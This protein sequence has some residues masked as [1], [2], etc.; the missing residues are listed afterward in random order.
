[1]VLTASAINAVANKRLDVSKTS[2]ERCHELIHRLRE[3][4]EAGMAGRPGFFVL[5]T[6][7]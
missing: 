1:M 2:G 6:G 3:M 4:A 7:T 5:R